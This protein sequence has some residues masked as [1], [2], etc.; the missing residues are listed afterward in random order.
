MSDLTTSGMLSTETDF[1]QRHAAVN[2]L[3][4]RFLR[5]DFA[6]VIVIFAILFLT[7]AHPTVKGWMLSQASL[8]IIYIIA[9]MGVAIQ[10]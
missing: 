7:P 1:A 5:Y 4:R 9:A 8:V 10:V 2:A 3:K 6:A